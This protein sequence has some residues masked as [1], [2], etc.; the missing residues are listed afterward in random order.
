MDHFGSS[1]PK[2]Q[3]ALSHNISDLGMVD[4]ELGRSPPGRLLLY[5][6]TQHF[7]LCLCDSC[8][9]VPVGTASANQ[10]EKLPVS[11]LQNLAT[12]WS[13]GVVTFN[14]STM[15]EHYISYLSQSKP[16]PWGDDTPSA[17]TRNTTGPGRYRRSIGR[18]DRR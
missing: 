17:Y 16:G 4:S 5:N 2:Q 12:E 10:H 13:P 9:D 18:G 6:R 8:K 15:V 14:P 1:F 7:L 11:Y 3:L